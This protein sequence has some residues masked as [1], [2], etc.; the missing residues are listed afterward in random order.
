MKFKDIPLQQQAQ[1]YHILTIYPDK[2]DGISLSKLIT[3]MFVK[4]QNNPFFVGNH[5]YIIWLDSLIADTPERCSWSL[6]VQ[7]SGSS[8]WCCHSCNTLKT[9][10]VNNKGKCGYIRN[11]NI[12]TRCGLQNYKQYGYKILSTYTITGLDWNSKLSFDF[13][14]SASNMCRY[15]LAKLNTILSPTVCF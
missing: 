12:L 5:K 6:S 14:H 1:M 7:I 4:Y 8:K 3:K 10:I 2:T 13:D 11:H 9:D 15:C